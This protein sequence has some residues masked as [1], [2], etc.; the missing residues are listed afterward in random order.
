MHVCAEKGEGTREDF[1]DAW[2]LVWQI[3]FECK[4]S[5]M[6]WQLVIKTLLCLMI[7][8]VNV[9][10][11]RVVGNS[12]GDEGSGGSSKVCLLLLRWV[13]DAGCAHMW[14]HWADYICH[15]AMIFMRIWTIL[16]VKNVAFSNT[17]HANVFTFLTWW[18]WWFTFF[19]WKTTLNWMFKLKLLLV[20]VRY[21]AY[22]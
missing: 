22:K 12:G 18:Q 21:T 4:C 20:S 6:S 1:L 14:T 8:F 15:T 3:K 19:I 17:L 16:W 7:C 2:A 5:S 13:L 11:E 9:H 10:E